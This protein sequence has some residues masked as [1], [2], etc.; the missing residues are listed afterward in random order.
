MSLELTFVCPLSNGIHARPASALE[1]VARNF[2]AEISLVNERTGNSANAKSVLAIIGTDIRHRDPCRSMLFY[3]T[4]SRDATKPCHPLPAVTGKLPCPR[5][6]AKPAPSSD[7]ANRLF[8]AS[9]AAA[10]STSADYA[11]PKPSR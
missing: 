2:A 7:M 8:T 11:S 10:S 5:R 3:V 6:Y 4:N 1:E 9:A